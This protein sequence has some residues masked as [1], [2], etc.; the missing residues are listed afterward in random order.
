MIRLGSNSQTR[1]LILQ[2]NGGTF[3]EDSIA[4]KVPIEGFCIEKLLP[5]LIK[6]NKKMI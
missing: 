1:A 4:T 2:Q 6:F 5:Y 3:D